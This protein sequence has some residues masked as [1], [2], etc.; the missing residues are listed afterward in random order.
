MVICTKTCLRTRL[1]SSYKSIGNVKSAPYSLPNVGPG[2]DSGV[3]A[4]SS[5]VTVSHLPAVGCHYFPP[6]LHFTF[7]NVRQMAPLLTEIID[8]QLQLT[9]H[10]SIP[11]E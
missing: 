3:Q 8:I 1:F 4:V 5:P 11:K 2:A 9:P 7:I 6:G 10:L